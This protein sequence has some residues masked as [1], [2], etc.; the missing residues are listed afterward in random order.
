MIRRASAAAVFL[1]THGLL[2]VMNSRDAHHDQAVMTLEAIVRDRASVWTS[3]WVLA[4][5]LSFG[6]TPSVRRSAIRAV[7]DI[8]NSRSTTI[9]PATRQ[10]W[11]LA[12][13][14]YQS[15]KDKGWSLVDCTTVVLCRRQGI[16][17]V[18]SH[19][20]HFVRAGL[21]ILLP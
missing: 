16:G 5:L 18:F 12:F 8:Q 11:T 13:A 20:H 9:I 3:D 6:Q 2:A 21:E 17:R 7:H 1:D 15:R 10:D 14:L 4:E 19:E